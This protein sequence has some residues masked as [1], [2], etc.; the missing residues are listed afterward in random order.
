MTINEQ[1]AM[2]KLSDQ[3]TNLS[4]RQF[5]GKLDVQGVTTWNLYFCLGRLVWASGGCH[6]NRRWYRHSSQYFPQVTPDDIRLREGDISQCWEYQVLIVLVKRQKITGEQ[7]VAVIKSVVS[8]ILF[9]ILQQEAKAPL[10]FSI[11]Q[12][13]TLDASLTLINQEQ[14]LKEAVLIWENWR[15]AGLTQLSP[16][17]VPVIKEQEELKQ[18][19][20]PK[21]YQTLMKVVN[22][23]R[24]LRELAAHIKQDPVAVTRSL[25]PYIR[26]KVIILASIADLPKP[27]LSMIAP[28]PT[29][30][31]QM[32]TARTEY[33]PTTSPPR[34]TIKPTSAPQPTKSGLFKRPLIAY[35]E[36]S[37]VDCQM[38][39]E[40]LRKADYGFL[41]I[42]D[43]IQALPIL[44]EKK[45][46]L[47]F[48]DLVMPIANGYEIC[49]QIRRIS[50]FKNTPV[51]ILT[52]NDGIVDRVR[53]KIAGAS[54]FLSK[55]IGDQKV[56][57]ALQ[58]HLNG[59]SSPQN[60][61]QPLGY[62]LS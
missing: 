38:M 5:T 59:T 39:E 36:D 43:S 11:Q 27:V 18:L 44:L 14:A 30:P 16:N 35:V 57:N 31:P 51:I 3:L 62:Q 19:A 25:L 2:D 45:P 28:P 60:V 7:A 26:K 13:N 8:E 61:S 41:S 47:I 6:P 33:I 4:Q 49:A 54:D 56:V 32:Q 40:I 48:L 10:T 34:E 1:L 21:V 50:S 24:T 58:K 52:G 12:Q 23:E 37:L 53:A 22:G 29:Q 17:V 9:E 20:S 15:K 55:P 42:K 46:D